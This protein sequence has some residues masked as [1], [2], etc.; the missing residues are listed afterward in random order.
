M[1]TTIKAQTRNVSQTSKQ[2]STSVSPFW[3]KMEFNR[4]GIISML[5]IFIGCL[6]GVAASF[7]AQDD[8]LKLALVAFPTIIS[9]ALVLAVAPMRAIFY[10]SGIAVI[11]DL[12]IL[13]F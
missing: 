7:G 9:L 4:Y 11:L 13:I 6:G 10:L 5:V 12:I 2:L 8:I 3:E 1:E